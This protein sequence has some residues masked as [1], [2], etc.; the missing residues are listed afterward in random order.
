MGTKV[1]I[2]EDRRAVHAR[3][4]Q[5]EAAPVAIAELSGLAVFEPPPL[6]DDP[7]AAPAQGC[8]V[9]E[10]LLVADYQGAFAANEERKRGGH[11]ALGGLVDDD[12]VEQ[13]W[14]QGQVRAGGEVGD[15]PDRQ[16]GQGLGDCP[17]GVLSRACGARRHALDEIRQVGGRGA[18]GGVLLP[19]L[20]PAGI[21]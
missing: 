2:E 5:T 9:D 3:R 15:R 19:E 4:G 20:G 13:S 21:Q 14:L 10:L 11:V 1:K 16:D 7:L 6:C 18:G 17:E 8:D 12:Q